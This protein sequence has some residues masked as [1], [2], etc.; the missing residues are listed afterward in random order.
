LANGVD[1]SALSLE[2]F[3]K[4]PTTVA[5][6][7][8]D[9]ERFK[10]FVKERPYI[11]LG[12]VLKSGHVIAYTN[13]ENIHNL[14]KELGSKSHK[15]YPKIMSPLD[16]QSNDAAGITPVINHPY[17]DLSGKGV[18]I[19]I[20]DTG[21]DYT[22]DVFRLD[23]GTSKIVGIW[24]QTLD[25]PRGTDLYYGAEFSRAQINEALASENPFDI[26]PSIDTDGHGTFL[27]SVAAGSS[28]EGYVGAAPRAELIVV[29]LRRANPFYIDF[30]L[31]PQDEPNLYS[32]TDFML[33]ARFIF[34]RAEDLNLPVVLCVGMGANITS[35]DGNTPLEDYINVAAQRIGYAVVTA[36]GNESNTRHHTQGVIQRTASTD[37]INIRIGESMT[38]TSVA[39]AIT[40]GVVAIL[41]EWGIVQGN[42]KSLD[43]D[44]TR[45][46]LIS[47]CS[48][49]E[50]ILYP[51]TRWGYGKLNL[52]GTFLRIKQSSITYDFPEQF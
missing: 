20:I 43:G 28:A 24:D 51:N 10:L 52:Y 3:V 47:G 32:A 33:G 11:K 41:M 16:Q 6:D 1:E 19:G 13:K 15:F 39:A 2:E 17:L 4:L 42:M 37:V 25:G 21:I 44:V 40:A 48:R 9:T 14:Y 26:V 8:L 7:A 46:L 34:Q 27:A 12:S 22:K 5:F 30:Y 36:A 18:I 23:N 29:K 38:G 31:L 49:D 35:H 50:G 45:L